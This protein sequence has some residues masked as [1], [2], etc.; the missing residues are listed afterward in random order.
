LDEGGHGG[1]ALDRHI[2]DRP[3]KA[4]ATPSEDGHRVSA[5]I[6][7]LFPNAEHTQGRP[8]PRNGFVSA[9]EPLLFQPSYGELALLVAQAFHADLV[10]PMNAKIG[11]GLLCPEIDRHFEHHF[12]PAVPIG[13]IAAKGEPLLKQRLHLG[14][15]PD[16]S[17]DTG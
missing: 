16:K 7:V 14:A 13:Q 17:I 8:P 2:L 6:A 9:E 10:E 12:A 5:A 4:K 3:L 15:L 11:F 1:H